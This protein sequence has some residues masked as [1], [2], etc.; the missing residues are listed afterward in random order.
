METGIQRNISTSITTFDKIVKVVK[1]K[2]FS[3][4]M[5]AKLELKKNFFSLFLAVLKLEKR[6]TTSKTEQNAKA[7]QNC[8]TCQCLLLVN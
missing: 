7:F 4:I 8:F 5:T 6:P 1:I 3:L 2:K